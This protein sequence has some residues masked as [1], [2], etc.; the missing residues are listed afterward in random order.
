MP[1]KDIFLCVESIHK[2]SLDCMF[3]YAFK[4]IFKNMSRRKYV[5]HFWINIWKYDESTIVIG[6][7]IL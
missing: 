3:S 4:Y 1:M 5:S 6:F 7:F 2:L